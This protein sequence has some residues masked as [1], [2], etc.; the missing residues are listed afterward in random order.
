MKLTKLGHAC[1]R[2]EKDGR[3]LVLDPGSFSGTGLL[4]GAE[5]VLITH[6]HV[7]HLDQNLIKSAA[8][9]LEV[10][11]CNAVTNSLGEVPVKIQTVREGDVFDVAGFSVRVIG[12]W[13]APTIP[14]A[15]IIQNIGFLIDDRVFYP[16]DA[17]TDPG[18]PVEVLL[19]PS[20]APWLR[21]WDFIEYLRMV[22]PDHAF[23]THDG[24]VNEI[25]QGMIDNFMTMEGKKQKSDMRRLKP[26]ES[27]EFA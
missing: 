7:D 12:E 17:L 6:E 18:V 26:G 1:W 19:A 13:H 8:P 16:G 5:A 3:T 14:D 27:A 23:S 11:T 25:G 20:N 10:W 15:P 9:D 22:R 2:F 24:L 21:V 4:D